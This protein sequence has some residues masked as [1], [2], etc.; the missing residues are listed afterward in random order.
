M[1]LKSK[2]FAIIIS[3]CD[4]YS[5][6][7]PPLGNL[8]KKYWK[9]CDK[10][11]YLLTESLNFKKIT[12]LNVGIKTINV[13][14][15]SWSRR[16]K[17]ALQSK[18]IKES[19]ILFVLDDFFLQS[20]VSNKKIDRYFYQF[21]K[22]KMEM[23]RIV[24][25]PGPLKKNKLVNN[26][27]EFDNNESYTISTQAAFW[28]K[29][30]LI[31]HLNDKENIWQFGIN[32]S[33]RVKQKKIKFFGVYNDIF[34]YKHHVIERGKWFPWYYMKFK[35]MNIGVSN[36]REVMSYFESILWLLKKFFL[37]YLKNLAK[38]F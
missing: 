24:A 1:T 20:K 5:D 22:F 38:F 11:I 17:I 30:S 35:N 2:K 18:I 23:L 26:I 33:E 37:N 10:E 13:K 3:S 36:K 21:K 16:L 7:W 14:S 8:Y 34:P 4:K 31:S 27:G 29:T 28:Q 32:G 15:K 25:R 19:D 6:L 9:N 12:K